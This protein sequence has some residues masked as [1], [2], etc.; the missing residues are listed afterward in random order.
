MVFPVNKEYLF[1]NGLSGAVKLV[2]KENAQKF[3][4]GEPT[5][6]LEPFFTYMTPQEEVEKAVQV[7]NFLMERAQ[8]CADQTIALTYDCN[9]QCP[10]CYEIWAKTPETMRAV[11]NEYKVNKVFE[12][13]DT[14]NTECTKKGPIILTGGEPLM[15]KND[16]IVKYILQKGYN[17]GYSFSIFTNGVELHHFLPLIS[18]V[19]I[20]HLQITLDGPRSLHDKKRIS[21]QV[22]STFDTI[23]GN[24]DTAREME[25]PI[26]VRT[27]V[28][29]N[30][31]AHL[32]EF[33]EFIAEK[34][35]VDDDN[36]R[37]S[38]AYE[39]DRRVD[40]EEFDQVAH[41]YKKVMEICSQPEFKFFEAYPFRKLYSLFDKSLFWP[42]FWNCNAV[43]KRYV[44][45]PFGDVYPCRAMLGWKEE[46]IGR[47]IP[48]LKFN[49][50]YEK[51]RSRTIFVMGSCAECDVALVCGGGCGYASLL[52]EKGLFNPVCAHTK[53]VIASYVKYLYEKRQVAESEP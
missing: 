6:E 35:W 30:I 14:L 29:E 42:S 15:K 23:V 36:I 51:W 39:C 11:I 49:K 52:N 19:D 16:A 47:Y 9:L 12:A 41:L 22:N 27:N 20:N 43:S 21:R 33:A 31:L 38:L 25:I 32:D 1:I 10:Y 34:K 3:F 7:C 45:D 5:K 37:F 24:I 4:K 48:E 13:L 18:S 2:S 17:S 40:P 26:L 8:Q 50:N 46:R 44:F 28:D 53:E